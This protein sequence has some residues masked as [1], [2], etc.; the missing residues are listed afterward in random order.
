MSEELRK[1]PMT[2]IRKLTALEAMDVISLIYC[3]CGI[4][5]VSEIDV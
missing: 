1:E 5:D 4:L 2:M 3:Y